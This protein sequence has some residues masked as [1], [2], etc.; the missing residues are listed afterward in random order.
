MS[1]PTPETPAT[2]A[3]PTA[4]AGSAAATVAVPIAITALTPG[5]IQPPGA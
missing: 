2:V 3:V 5:T 4:I 1:L